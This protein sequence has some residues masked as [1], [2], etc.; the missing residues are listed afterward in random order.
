MDVVGLKVKVNNDLPFMT[1]SCSILAPIGH[2]SKSVS[3]NIE[4]KA[5]DTISASYFFFCAMDAG[6][7][8]AL[9][10]GVKLLNPDPDSLEDP[11]KK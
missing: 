2:N 6:H 7:I 9:S 5:G 10:V 3:R 1:C 4:L 11:R 8:N